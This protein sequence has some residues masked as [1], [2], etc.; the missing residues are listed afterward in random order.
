MKGIPALAA[1]AAVL[2]LPGCIAAPLLVGAA[3]AGGGLKFGSH[4]EHKSLEAHMPVRTAAALGHNMDPK[5]VKISDV[6]F[7]HGTASWMADTPMGR[8]SCTDEG[9]QAYC[10]KP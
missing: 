4:V 7:D 10:R 6:K 1:L 2:T 5:D 3:G 8:Y 9:V